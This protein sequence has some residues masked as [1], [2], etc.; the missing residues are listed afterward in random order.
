ME[1]I[2]QQRSSK[3][4]AS[5]KPAKPHKIAARVSPEPGRK[6]HAATSAGRLAPTPSWARRRLFK[7]VSDRQTPTNY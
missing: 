7:L 2:S 5:G 3:E 4:C 1:R 6:I